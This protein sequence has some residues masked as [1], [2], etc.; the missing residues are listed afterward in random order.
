M[1]RDTIL[2]LSVSA[3][4]GELR[5][6]GL[7]TQGLKVDLQKRLLG[8]YG[9]KFSDASVDA[10]DYVSPAGSVGGD[11]VRASDGTVGMVPALKSICTL[12][13]VKDS[14]STFN[15]TDSPDINQWITEFEEMAE[16]VEW[17][18]LQMFVYAR[19]L[20]VGAARMFIRSQ[21]GI[22]DWMALK[23]CL[24]KEFGIRFS[25]AEVH[26]QMR[27]RKLGRNE[28]M[29]EYLYNLLELAK[30][31]DLD[32]KS[33]VEYF[34]EGIPDSRFNKSVLYHAKD[35]TELKQQIK[36]YEKIRVNP[37][38]S[39]GGKG[40]AVY[41]KKVESVKSEANKSERKCY[42]CGA[43]GHLAKD[44]S[45]RQ[46]KCFRCQKFGHR[47]F[48]CRNKASETGTVKPEQ[49]QA[50][51][52][53]KG[54]NLIFKDIIIK[55]KVLS[56]LIDTGCDVCLMRNDMLLIVGDVDFIP[57]RVR[58]YGIGDSVIE[59][60]GR[61]DIPVEIDGLRFDVTFY[62]V[63]END[64]IHSIMI[65]NSLMK[66]AEVLIRNGEAVFKE[67]T[68]E[69]LLMKEFKSI[70]L[71]VEQYVPEVQ[72]ELDH[73]EKNVAD[74][75]STIV[76]GYKPRNDFESPVKMRIVVKDDIPVY[77][78]PRR[79]P[80]SDQRI[81]DEQVSEWLKQ[82]IIQ[83]STSEYASPIVLA[84]RKDGS[85]RLCCDYRKL[86][87][88]IV[89]D[90]FPMPLIEEVLDKLQ[91]ANVYTTLDLTNGFFHV[92][93]EESS[94]K[95]TSFVT[96]NGQFEFL[97]VPFG[98]SNSPAVFTRFIFAVL[99]DLI[100]DGTIVVYM[101]DIIIPSKDEIEGV[102]KFEIVL[103]RAERCGLRIKWSKCQIL[104]RKVIFL[105]Y[106]VQNGSIKPS[107]EKVKAVN[108]FP[109]P[110]D[111]KAVQRFLGLASY[112]R[113]F[114]EDYAVIA[115][116]LTD[117]LRKNVDFVIS[118]EMLIACRQLKEALSSAPVLK[119]YD[120]DA[121]TEVHTD[122]SK[123]GY[124][125]ILL[126]KSVD[127][128]M[129][130]PVQFMSRRTKIHE[131]K[132][133]SYEL[134]VLAIIEALK[135]WR[136][137]LLGI[138]FKIVTDCSAFKMTMDKEDVP[139]RVSRW[140]MFLQDFSYEIEHR[141]GTKMKHADALSR[142]SCL[143]VESS[144]THRVKMAQE[145]D[146]RTKVIRA[147][148]EYGDYEDFYMKNGVLFKDPVK[149]L[150]VIPTQMEDEIIILAHKQGVNKTKELIEKQYHIPRLSEKVMRIVKGCV[151]C[152]ITDAKSGKK[153]GFL[154]PID[155]E[156][157]PLKTYH[158]DHVGP[159]EITRKL[160]NHIFVVVDGFTKFIWLYP[161]KSTDAK[162]V[163]DCLERQSAVF[164]NP[165]RIITD[166]GAAFTS[167]VFAE[168]CKEEG[169][170]HLLIATGVPRGNGQ[171]E[172]MHRIIVPMLAKFC[173]EDP[174]SWYKHVRRVQ[175][176]INSTVSRSTQYSPFKLLTGVEMRIP[177][178]PDLREILESEIVDELIED[179]DEMRLKAKENS[180]K[181][182][183]ENRKTFNSK[184]RIEEEYDVN[185]LV[186]I[187][188]TQ[189]GTGLKL[190]GKF[191]GPYK[192]IKRL[193][194][195][196]YEVQKVGDHEGPTRT[197]TVAEFMKRWQSEPYCR[198]EGRVVG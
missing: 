113:K 160:Y 163:I 134:E 42:K 104:Q 120:P 145:T 154:N 43:T 107:D 70:C 65:G 106:V 46:I 37:R 76:N 20:L 182:Q 166:R 67:L 140:A 4:K 50:N 80:W 178:Y 174:K 88:K 93:L 118:D 157:T 64:A 186:A 47:S 45:E 109:I 102:E 94:R 112:F 86:N 180:E 128:Q 35:V 189:F 191:M 97:F 156:D 74:R 78:R 155:K 53:R 36:V 77:Q 159:M 34:I 117:L 98:I 79:I 103:K 27:N 58:L 194:H 193:S 2:E 17:T 68:D 148:L 39:N 54:P 99:M 90:H 129:L 59:T 1:D 161:T 115:K 173:M 95:Y 187:K 69:N 87:D 24:R 185:E 82:K 153:E 162:T 172:R 16:V 72:L 158:V 126:Q 127:D 177:D 73:L 81:V 132:Y 75:V 3:L 133:H 5:N 141:P 84:A 179:R 22:K 18:S 19:Q 44:C 29:L 26:R 57:E 176:M 28:T 152:L 7:S 91:K 190:R 122:A 61:F 89:R 136:V 48:E 183:E 111:R 188:R 52:V 130:H 100:R 96:S 85:K 108:N 167:N 114:I 13:D 62:V 105:G 165:K 164:G 192:I 197:T 25:S 41:E 150:I 170:E 124:G 56:A 92:P 71:N 60:M 14:L 138:P 137:Y 168:Y 196:R 55:D 31:I 147:I 15:G 125:A 135:K 171:V 144:L 123:Y 151:E 32:E 169:I 121:V 10:D 116:P 6:L 184:R 38:S 110:T 33:I 195:G 146:D 51:M 198:Q 11:A 83:P 40:L 101:D 119:L 8:Y 181:I 9:L 175:T 66:K 143:I 23:I 49:G 142:M 131:E 12:K 63:K 21:S 139:P 149:E 30:R